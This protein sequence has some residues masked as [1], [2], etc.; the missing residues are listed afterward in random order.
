[1]L[2]SVLARPTT[3]NQIH[4]QVKRNFFL[5][6]YPLCLIGMTLQNNGETRKVHLLD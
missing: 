2:M 6:Y 1:M 4:V 3:C 5:E